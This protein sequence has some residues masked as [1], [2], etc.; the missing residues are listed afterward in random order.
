[1]ELD[2]E[3]L[4]VYHL[5]LDFLVFANDVIEAL[6][7]GRSHLADQFTASRHQHRLDPRPLPLVKLR[8]HHRGRPWNTRRA[9]W[10]WRAVC[11]ALSVQHRTRA[12]LSDRARARARARARD[13]P[14]IWGK[15]LARQR[16]NP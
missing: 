10:K 9:T 8:P 4:D 5:A 13:L 15:A 3:R 7:R 1:M 12:A 14:E 2:H 16:R 6:P 11:T